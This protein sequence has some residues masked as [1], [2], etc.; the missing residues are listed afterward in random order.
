MTESHTLGRGAVVDWLVPAD[1]ATQLVPT[2]VATQPYCLAGRP[3]RPG[4]LSRTDDYALEH[5]LFVEPGAKTSYIPGPIA[6][7]AI[8]TEITAPESSDLSGA[9]SY[10]DLQ[11][12]PIIAAQDRQGAASDGCCT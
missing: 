9:S 11:A 5:Y 6:A 7:V 4:L 3:G 8:S 2:D 10:V 1:V 12:K